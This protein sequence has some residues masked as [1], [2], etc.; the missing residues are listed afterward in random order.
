VTLLSSSSELVAQPELA[1]SAS[2][3]PLIK[4]VLIAEWLSELM[5][6]LILGFLVYGIANYCRVP[7]NFVLKITIAILIVFMVYLHDLR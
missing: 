2:N 3:D 6:L 4:T 5:S 1:N 7:K